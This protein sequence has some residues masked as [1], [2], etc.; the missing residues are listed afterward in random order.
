MVSK[1]PLKIG[2]AG[3]AISAIAIG[4]GVGLSKK[5]SDANQASMS[6]SQAKDLSHSPSNIPTIGETSIVSKL[7]NTSYI[8]QQSSSS[9]S[10]FPP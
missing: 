8:P 5:N 3:V 6:A 10:S 1:R 9:T 2:A 7:I 4:L